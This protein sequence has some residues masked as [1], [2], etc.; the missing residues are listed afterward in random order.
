L[1]EFGKLLL[2]AQGYEVLGAEDGFEGL[3]AL[4]Q[5]LP[6][7]K[8]AISSQRKEITQSTRSPSFPLKFTF[9]SSSSRWIFRW[10]RLSQ[11]L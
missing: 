6:D 11:Y 2:G 7:I 3:S 1:R 9:A 8:C 5:S 10:R 4:K